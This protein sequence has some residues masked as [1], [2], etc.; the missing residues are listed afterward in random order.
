MTSSTLRIVSAISILCLA[1]GFIVWGLMLISEVNREQRQVRKHVY[2]ITLLNKSARSVEN[3]TTKLASK[4]QAT[5]KASTYIAKLHKTFKRIRAQ[6]LFEDKV[7]ALEAR[8]SVLSLKLQKPTRITPEEKSRLYRGYLRAVRTGVFSARKGLRNI[9]I[10]L[11]KKWTEMT[12]LALVSCVMAM[13][14]AIF[15]LLF[16]RSQ[17]KRKRA[18]R[19]LHRRE[20]IHQL[21]SEGTHDGLWDWELENDTL[22]TSSRWQEITGRSLSGH[23]N[24]NDWKQSIHPE[25]LPS[26]EQ[27]LARVIDEQLEFFEH[28]HRIIS[29]DETIRWIHSRGKTSFEEGKLVRIAGSIADLSEKGTLHDALTGLPNRI[30][31]RQHLERLLARLHRRAGSMFAV[32]FMDLDRFKFINDTYGHLIGDEVLI[33]MAKLFKSILRT[34]DVVA[35][36]SGDEFIIVLDEIQRAEDATLVANR[37]LKDAK[38]PFSVEEF[39]LVI[40]TSI[41]ITVV[42]AGD[43]SVD[44]ILEE[45]DHAM[46]QAKQ[47]GKAAYCLYD[48]QTQEKIDQQMALTTSFLNALQE[49]TITPT[50]QP[51]FSTSTGTLEAWNCTIGWEHKRGHLV[52]LHKEH[53]HCHKSHIHQAFMLG[54]EKIVSHLQEQQSSFPMMSSLPI[55]LELPSHV[56]LQPQ[57]AKHLK[58]LLRRY[59]RAA[60]TL[61]LCYAAPLLTKRF[62]SGRDTLLELSKEGFAISLVHLEG[63]RITLP[64]LLSLPLCGLWLSEASKKEESFLREREAWVALA[65]SLG[66]HRIVESKG[67]WKKVEDGNKD[68]FSMIFGKAFGKPVKGELLKKKLSS[69]RKFVSSKKED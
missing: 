51:I 31:V 36:V 37:I 33:H 4:Q 43:K 22:N 15:F 16:L 18:E 24:I 39:E 13:L 42:E 19:T 59:H 60:K 69:W 27:E 54:V 68:G 21:T 9:S 57:L 30:F 32:M 11:S 14:M 55:Y 66:L 20:S 6:G 62:E 58:Q 40:S 12:L 63:S 1:I 35:R 38:T 47:G 50:F 56:L 34:V 49:E 2:F 3:I 26:F 25:D 61:C 41:G 52:T 23:G 8:V 5:K 67:K 10:R 7:K 46:F 45:A 53:L 17:T 28:E 48:Q 29:E 44:D 65:T 64:E